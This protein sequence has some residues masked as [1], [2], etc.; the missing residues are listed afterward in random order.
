M[1][2][3][4]RMMR[5]AGLPALLWAL[6]ACTSVPLMDPAP[7]RAARVMEDLSRA[8]RMDLEGQK[9]ALQEAQRVHLAAPDE[10]SRVRLGGLYAQPVAGLR[11]DARALAL[12]APPP[13]EPGGEATPMQRLGA[14]LHAQVSERVRG[15]REE[16]RRQ[17]QLRR[18]LEALRA[19]E[20]A[21]RSREQRLMEK[22]D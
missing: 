20:R 6:A 8:A 16:A 14:L 19:S 7:A 18:Q 2:G 11:D 1:S 9:Q 17:D 15:A 13:A 4:R 3:V 12:L 21:I 10:E 5:A 22:F